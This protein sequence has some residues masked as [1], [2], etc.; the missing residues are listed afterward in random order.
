MPKGDIV[1]KRFGKLTVVGDYGSRTKDGK[2]LYRC[3]CDCGNEVFV[4]GFYLKSGHTKSCGCLRAETQNGL[5]HGQSNTRL[6]RIYWSMKGRCNSHNPNYKGRGISVCDEWKT[7][8]DAFYKWAME[9]GYG[10]NLTLDRIDNEKGY[11]PH[12]CR[13]ITMK[14]QQNNKRNNR[15]IYY[16]G[17][18]HTLSEW[19]D[20]LGANYKSLWSYV[21][22]NGGFLNGW[23]KRY[24]NG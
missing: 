22:K 24:E 20:I 21:K 23:E 8:F 16:K 4:R 2:V 1:G 13:W 9:N 7:N 14:E 18:T 12:N 15:R 6:W 11:S 19:A 10:E 5:I 3:R 17:E